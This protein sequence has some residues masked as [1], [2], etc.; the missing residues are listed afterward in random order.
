MTLQPMVRNS[1]NVQWGGGQKGQGAT[2]AGDG[3]ARENRIDGW[4]ELYSE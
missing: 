1:L 4:R 2:K 3:G